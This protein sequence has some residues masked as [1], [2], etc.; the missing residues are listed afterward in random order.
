MMAWMCCRH[1]PLCDEEMLIEDGLGEEVLDLKDDWEEM[2][3]P[4]ENAVNNYFERGVPDE[5]DI[6]LDTLSVMSEE[7]EHFFIHMPQSFSPAEML[8]D[9]KIPDEYVNTVKAKK[10][11]SLVDSLTEAD[12]ERELKLFCKIIWAR[13]CQVTVQNIFDEPDKVKVTTQQWTKNIRRL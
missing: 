2:F 12:Y 3:D 9:L 8:K 5:D 4:S 13:A 11:N 1:S 6:D 10:I 7:N